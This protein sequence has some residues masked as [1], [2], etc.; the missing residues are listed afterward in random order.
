[1]CDYLYPCIFLHTPVTVPASVLV[2]EPGCLFLCE[3]TDYKCTRV[4]MPF[5]N[6]LLCMG[7]LYGTTFCTGA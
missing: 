2:R 1:M 7:G 3:Y 4:R 6:P 5:F